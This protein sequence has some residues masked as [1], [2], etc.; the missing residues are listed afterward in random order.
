MS[1]GRADG[2]EGC[3]DVT[4]AIEPAGGGAVERSASASLSDVIEVIL[5]KGIIIDAFV[6]VSVLHIDLLT[7]D[8]R[9][10]VAS[11]DSYL[12]YAEAMNRIEPRQ[13]EGK[14]LPELLQDVTSADTKQVIQG[15]T[16]GVLQTAGEA[17]S[18]F[19]PA[20]TERAAV[21]GS[22]DGS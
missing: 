6:K 2:G 22:R 1:T 14:G 21:N 13:V 19:K 10:V 8:A 4:T 15:A 18:G 11:I 20:A 5:D 12:R 7:V 16:T 17:L 9:V 3:D